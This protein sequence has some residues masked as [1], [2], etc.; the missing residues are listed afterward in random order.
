[1]LYAYCEHSMIDIEIHKGYLF[2]MDVLVLH[3]ITK[4]IQNSRDSYY[5]FASIFMFKF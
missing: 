2:L 3:Y 4:K 1:M 5:K